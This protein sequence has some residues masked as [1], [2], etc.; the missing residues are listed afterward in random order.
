MKTLFIMELGG[1]ADKISGLQQQ[2]SDT[3]TEADEKIRKRIETL[4]KKIIKGEDSTGDLIRDF[5]IVV[6]HDLSEEA[7][8][9]YRKLEEMLKGKVEFVEAING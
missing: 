5:V 9:P 3:K 8:Q 1:E 6:H 7:E 4:T 2:S